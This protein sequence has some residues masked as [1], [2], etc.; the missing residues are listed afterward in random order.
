MLLNHR[1]SL[2]D[3][4]LAPNPFH[5]KCTLAVCT[6]NHVRANLKQDDYII[7]V[8][9]VRLRQKLNL[10]SDSWRLIYAMKVDEIKELDAYYNAADYK[11]K[12][13]KLNGS[14]IDMCGDNFYKLSNGKLAHTGE[15]TDHDWP[16]VNEQDCK[17]NRVFIGEPMFYFGSSA[18]EIPSN[19][20]WGSK[21]IRQLNRRSVNVT[22]ILG[23]RCSDPWETGDF[24]AFKEFLNESK[25]D[26]EP[27][28]IDFD[29]W[30]SEPEN[31][32]S[33]AG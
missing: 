10:P 3:T 5:G 26:G 14:K 16:E 11:L 23:G 20:G 32:S 12:I 33:C 4:G 1:K 6:P 21:L 22:Y 7:G 19:T 27:K 15:S 2:Y 9:G 8:A 18:R 13:P 17:G 25:I 28:P 31:K 30:N 29:H 24:E